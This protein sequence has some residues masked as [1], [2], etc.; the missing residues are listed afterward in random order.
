MG[1][2]DILGLIVADTQ[3]GSF[4]WSSGSGWHSGHMHSVQSLSPMYIPKVALETVAIFTSL[5]LPLWIQV[6]PGLSGWNVGRFL[7][8]LLDP[9]GDRCSDALI[10]SALSS[11]RPDVMSVVFASF[12]LPVHSLWLQHD[13]D[14]SST[15][16]FAAKGCAWLCASQGSPSQTP[17]F[18]RGSLSFWEWW[19][20]WQVCV[21][22]SD[23]NYCIV[24]VGA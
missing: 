8:P 19:Q 15:E 7:S 11:C 5:N 23:A 18:A 6:I 2:F 12:Y 21:S 20:V 1:C 9:S 24:C 4:S 22:L 14:S 13:Q 10:C 3:S 17:R 16:V